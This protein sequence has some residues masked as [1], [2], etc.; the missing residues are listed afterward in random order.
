[1]E[2]PAAGLGSRMLAA[3]R[4]RT[5]GIIQPNYLPWRGYFDFINEVDVFV[6]LDDVQ[7]TKRDWRNRNRIRTRDGRSVWL[8]V[9][10]LGGTDQL[11]NEAVIDASTGWHETHLATLTHNYGK[12]PHF[13]DYVAR[14]RPVFERRHEKLSDL[15][16]A[17]TMEIAVWLGIR[18]EFV[19]ASSLGATGVKDERLL[20]LVTKLDGSTYLSGPAAAAYIQPQL[21]DEAGIELRFKRYPE[22]PVYPQIAEPFDPAVSILDLLFMVG[23]HAPEYI[24]DTACVAAEHRPALA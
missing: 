14:L 4:R 5:V 12:T 10:V 3:S 2:F 13:R 22:Y 17:L 9:P 21:W 16:I 20:E 18:T 8:S 23:P 24:W 1:M 19:T 11:I 15:T 6:F 7:Y